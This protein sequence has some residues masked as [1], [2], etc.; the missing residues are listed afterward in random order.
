M[1]IRDNRSPLA[2]LSEDLDG[3]A[4]RQLA[5]NL[6]NRVRGPFDPDAECRCALAILRAQSGQLAQAR[7]LLDEV[8]LLDPLNLM[9]YNLRIQLE[10]QAGPPGEGDRW[11]RRHARI[12]GALSRG[13]PLEHDDVLDTLHRIDALERRDRV[14]DVAD[15]LED[16]LFGDLVGNGL[17]APVVADLYHRLGD[18]HATLGHSELAW[19]CRNAAALLAPDNLLA[20]SAFLGSLPDDGQ[21]RVP[22][23]EPSAWDLTDDPDGRAAAHALSAAA[24][25]SGR[26]RAALQRMARLPVRDKDVL[27]LGEGLPPAY[28]STLGAASWWG[29]HPEVPPE[30]DDAAAF[31]VGPLDLSELPEGH[32]DRVFVHGLGALRPG[33]ALEAVA[34]AL[35]PDGKA[36]AVLGPAWSSAWGHGLS[37]GGQT[38]PMPYWAHLL[39]TQAEIDRFALTAGVAKEQLRLQHKG[40]TAQEMLS[41]LANPSVKITSLRVIKR[42]IPMPHV[43]RELRNAHPQMENVFDWGYE[44]MLEH[45]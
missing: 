4:L 39:W 12:E 1:P 37:E 23:P 10:S 45:A 29:Q 22:E 25:T 21:R 28:T 3:P 19:H 26:H 7:A 31:R 33:I 14:Q 2:R 41:A 5:Q 8:R 40:P 32:F 17:E 13:R 15:I 11:M 44:A 42:A 18:L 27:D 43:R 9:S 6:V 34:R 20:A 35:R 16:F 30:G 24:I 38:A 36:L